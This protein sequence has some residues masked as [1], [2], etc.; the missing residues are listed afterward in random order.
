MRWLREAVD[1]GQEGVYL[2]IMTGAAPYGLV[3]SGHA[4]LREVR[5]VE[6]GMNFSVLKPKE[7]TDTYLVATEL[8]R[9]AVAK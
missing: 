3:D 4:V 2:P 1:A 8:G 6:T 9:K 7:W 5:R